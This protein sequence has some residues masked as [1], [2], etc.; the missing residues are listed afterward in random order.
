MIRLDGRSGLKVKTIAFPNQSLI[1]LGKGE[2]SLR[3]PFWL[4]SA[5][6]AVIDNYYAI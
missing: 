1:P 6:L 5:F 2:D 3:N 4:N